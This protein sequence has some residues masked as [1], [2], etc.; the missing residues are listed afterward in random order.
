MPERAVAAPLRRNWPPLGTRCFAAAATCRSCWSRC[1]CSA[2]STIARRLRSRG[3]WSVSRWRS[4]GLA[5]ARVCRRHRAARRID[6]RHAAPDGR[7]AVDAR[8][9]LDRA[10]SAVPRQHARGAGVRA[11][12]GHVV[13]A[14]DRRAVE[15][16][17]SRAHR[18]ARR[19]I[20]AE[21]VRR[22]LSRVG[23]RGAR[24]DPRVRR[25]RP[26]NVPFQWRKVIVQESHGLCAIG[27]AFLVLDTLE[28]SVRLGY[29]H[30]DPAWLAIFVATLIPFLRGDRRKKRRRRTAQI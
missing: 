5:A 10:P 21:R 3:S 19:S 14:A 23:E 20:S 2:C 24:D 1:S 4:A 13:S 16:H 25:Y 12:L 26:S 22:Q 6:A 28:D 8:R 27:T 18:R 15:L 29:F 11:A 9:V 17:L 7:F 30:V